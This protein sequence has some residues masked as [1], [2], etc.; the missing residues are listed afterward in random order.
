M[1]P[2]FLDSEFTDGG[3]VVSLT[4]G[5]R[6]PPGRFLVLIS[7]TDFVDPRAIV[8]LEGLHQMKNP[9]TSSKIEPA[10]FLLLP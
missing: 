8:R 2:H 5:R 4:A 3:E 7:V 9:M 10:N 1:I 6:L